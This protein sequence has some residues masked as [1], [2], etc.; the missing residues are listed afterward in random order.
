MDQIKFLE[1]NLV[2]LCDE[3]RACSEPYEPSLHDN[4]FSLTNS[5]ASLSYQY[6]FRIPMEDIVHDRMNVSMGNNP[7]FQATGSLK[8]K[9]FHFYFY[10]CTQA[11]YVMSSDPFVVVRN[12]SELGKI[13]KETEATKKL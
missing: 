5:V 11:S 4:G 2:R 7:S 9:L 6:T 13:C 8:L 10:D 1:D 12:V 3:V